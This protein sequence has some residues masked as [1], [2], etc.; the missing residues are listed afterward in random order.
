MS[1]GVIQ[2]KLGVQPQSG[3]FGPITAR[4][5]R[6]NFGLNNVQASHFI[7][8]LHH[9]SGGFR[10]FTENL[11]Y[12]SAERIMEKFRRHFPGGLQ[13][14]QRFVRQPEMLAN[15]VYAN[16]MG[17]GNE[18]SG[19]GW[20]FRGRGA[21]QLTGR[22]NYTLFSQSIND[23]RVISNPEIVATDYILESAKWF[24]DTNNLW[25][26]CRD[27]TRPTIEQLTRRINGGLNGIEDRVTQTNRAM[28]WL[29]RQ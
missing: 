18:A 11:T 19:D 22:N 4:A 7:G 3:I 17:N 5:V 12:T 13:E 16:R 27:I 14:A 21:I 9:E 10:T 6:D 25:S 23:P 15:R 2:Q 24:F 1:I 26:I 28:E 8:Q 20:R 29:T